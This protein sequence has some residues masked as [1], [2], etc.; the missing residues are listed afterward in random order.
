MFVHNERL[1]DF[2]TKEALIDRNIHKRLLISKEK[3][4][5]IR[6]KNDLY[7]QVIILKLLLSD[8]NFHLFFHDIK[9]CLKKYKVHKMILGKMGFPENWER[10]NRIKKYTKSEMI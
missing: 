9:V 10:I 8:V 2:H 4:H 5:Y 6:G 3:G 7:A 1:F